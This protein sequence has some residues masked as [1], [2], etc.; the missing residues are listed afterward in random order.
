MIL[1]LW[2]YLDFWWAG[3]LRRSWYV[4]FQGVTW[5]GPL[6]WISFVV[7]VAF[8]CP[9]VAGGHGTHRKHSLQ[10]PSENILWL[11][12]SG[13]HG[14]SFF[15]QNKPII[16]LPWDTL[17]GHIISW[18]HNR[19]VQDWQSRFAVGVSCQRW[20]SEPHSQSQTQHGCGRE[21]HGISSQELQPCLGTDNID[22]VFG[23]LGPSTTHQFGEKY[24]PDVSSMQRGSKGSRWQN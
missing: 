11:Q 24:L 7:A 4:Y 17:K 12:G 8:E 9:P 23:S 13:E 1:G 18:I 10:M 3:H 20:R 14:V 16:S 19:A 22:K 6:L 21:D 2:I 15:G 5:D